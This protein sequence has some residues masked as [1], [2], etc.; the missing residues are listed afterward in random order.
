MTIILSVLLTVSICA[1]IYFAMSIDRLYEKIDTL[2]N[3]ISEFKQTTENTLQKLKEIDEFNN[4]ID[5]F[6]CLDK[7]S[8]FFGISSLIKR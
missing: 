6:I 5:S 3:W 8:L 2:S 7:V 4:F 1:N